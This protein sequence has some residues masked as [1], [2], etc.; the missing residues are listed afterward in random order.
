VP[1]LSKTIQCLP[2]RATRGQ[3]R[4]PLFA[5]GRIEVQVGHSPWAK[6][7]SRGLAEDPARFTN[8]FDFSLRLRLFK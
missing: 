1:V 6:S 8:L 5:L 3:V 7:G 2:S 4:S